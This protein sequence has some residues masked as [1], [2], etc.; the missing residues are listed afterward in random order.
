MLLVKSLIITF[1]NY[2]AM[3][4]IKIILQ[5]NLTHSFLLFYFFSPYTM[6]PPRDLKKSTSITDGEKRVLANRYR[7]E[8]KLGSGNF[9]TAFLV[10]DLKMD[11]LYIFL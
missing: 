6:P 10:T 4:K 11:E 8:K 3:L 7:V 5:H 1:R 9:G 2:V